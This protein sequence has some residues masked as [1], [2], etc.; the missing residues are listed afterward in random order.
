MRVVD[1]ANGTGSPRSR[2]RTANRIAPDRINETQ[3]YRVLHGRRGKCPKDIAIGAELSVCRSR[4][5]ARYPQIKEIDLNSVSRD[6]KGYRVLDGRIS[7]DA[8]G[9]RRN[10]DD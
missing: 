5:S 6:E 10:D 8:K 4:L 2:L 9:V 1:C 7:L 3:H